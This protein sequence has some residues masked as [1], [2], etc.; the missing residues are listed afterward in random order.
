MQSNQYNY[1]ESP[2]YPLQNF[3]DG[4]YL[5][6]TGSFTVP[7]FRA[8]DNIP[9]GILSTARNGGTV[10]EPVLPRYFPSLK[11]CNG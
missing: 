9:I 4:K 11:F 2:T 5:G 6:R 10:N 8:V 7:P 3:K 1:P